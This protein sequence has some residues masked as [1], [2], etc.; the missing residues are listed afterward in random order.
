VLVE[1]PHRPLGI[2]FAPVATVA[3]LGYGQA[4]W[5]SGSRWPTIAP[6][7]LVNQR[8]CSLFNYPMLA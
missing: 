2:E 6:H 1:C 7:W 5:Q 8:H 4:A 3:G